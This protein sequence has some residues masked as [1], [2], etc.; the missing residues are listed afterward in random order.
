MKELEIGI[1]GGTGGIGRWFVDFFEKEGYTVHVSGRRT[2]MD[3]DEMAQK[4]QV[5]IVSVRSFRIT[6]GK[7]ALS[8]SHSGASATTS[9]ARN[10][11]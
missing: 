3:M 7:V 2:G 8:P 6:S 11:A 1:I 4:C 5:V 9:P 10:S